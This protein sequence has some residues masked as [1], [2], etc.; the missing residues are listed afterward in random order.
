MNFLILGLTV[1]LT[2]ALASLPLARPAEWADDLGNKKAWTKLFIFALLTSLATLLVGAAPRLD[3]DLL[4]FVA[5][6][7]GVSLTSVAFFYSVVTDFKLRKA[8]RRLA[9]IT[10]AIASVPAL[11]LMVRE[12]DWITASASIS[13]A[14]VACVAYLFGGRHV[15]AGDARAL[16]IISLVL[17]PLMGWEAFMWASAFLG[18]SFIVIGFA[19]AA[20]RKTA[21]TSFPAVPMLIFPYLAALVIASYYDFPPLLISMAI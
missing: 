16:F 4:K 21:K 10:L 9:Q 13:L 20:V 1:L 14:I 7:L 17:L 3:A 5:L 6:C 19:V 15:G 8:D 2:A 11:G 18:V 12:S